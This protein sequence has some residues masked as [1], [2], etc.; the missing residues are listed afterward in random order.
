MAYRSKILP[1]RITKQEQELHIFTNPLENARLYLLAHSDY[2]APLTA[3]SLA[4]NSKWIVVR[5][6][7]HKIR[8]WRAVDISNV[9]ERLRDWYIFFQ[10]R[11]EL[12][13]AYKD[14]KQIELRSDFKA[15]NH[16]DLPVD[17]RHSQRF[18][19]R[20]VRPTDMLYYPSLDREPLV[21]Q[22]LLY[23]FSKE[24]AVPY[25]SVFRTFLSNVCLIIH[26]DQQRLR[27]EAVF[28][29]VALVLTIIAFVIL[30]LM[31]ISLVVSVLGT[32]S[33]LKSMYSNDP[34]G[35]IEWREPKTILETGFGTT[36]NYR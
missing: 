5:N 25:E 11:R 16:F 14:I 20:H 18:D 23:Y 2:Q 34:D 19:V 10:I 33:N 36:S 15:V 4:K 12:R 1:P 8:S 3:Q 9:D 28:R 13:R 27:R 26:R 21:L 17:P 24:C 32:T 31:L 6:N 35:G 29:K 30:G 7:I 22:S